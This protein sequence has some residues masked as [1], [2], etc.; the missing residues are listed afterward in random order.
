MTRR[1]RL[2]AAAILR[3]ILL[4]VGEGR[5]TA[6]GPHA[7]RVT[8]RLEGAVTALEADAGSR[9]PRTGGRGTQDRLD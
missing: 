3:S 7:S 6:P 2:Q 8:R 1:D 9:P 5:M 4:A